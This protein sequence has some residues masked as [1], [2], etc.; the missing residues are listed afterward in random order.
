MTS[1][2][3]STHKRKRPQDVSSALTVDCKEATVASVVDV[4][5]EK[6]LRNR[7]CR[8]AKIKS[9]NDVAIM[10]LCVEQFNTKHR[11]HE[12]SFDNHQ[13][14]E[15]ELLRVLLDTCQEQNDTM[16]SMHHLKILCAALVLDMLQGFRMLT[17][18]RREGI[19]V[20]LRPSDLRE[21]TGDQTP[22]IDQKTAVGGKD[23]DKDDDNNDDDNNEDEDEEQDE[24]DG[25]EDQQEEDGSNRRKKRRVAVERKSTLRSSDYDDLDY[26]T[27]PSDIESVLP[28]LPCQSP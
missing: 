23:D 2:P 9:D 21:W 18:D 10:Q 13:P 11:I 8:V 15:I 22:T 7:L 19:Q 14:E 24:Q 12:T 5:S 25:G 26:A 17:Y 27:I 4:Q 16:G 1:A 20:Y 28:L 3:I 6:A